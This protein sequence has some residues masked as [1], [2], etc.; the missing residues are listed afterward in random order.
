MARPVLRTRPSERLGIQHRVVATR[1]GTGELEVAFELLSIR[2]HHREGEIVIQP[3]RLVP[4]SCLIDLPVHPC[5]H[6]VGHI[7]VPLQSLRE[8]TGHEQ[9]QALRIGTNVRVVESASSHDVVRVCLREHHVQHRCT[10]DLRLDRI[11]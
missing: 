11:S 7:S 3:V 4:L 8:D 1:E 5:N 9:G 10:T 2:V 6:L